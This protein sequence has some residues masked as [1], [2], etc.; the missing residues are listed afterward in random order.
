MVVAPRPLRDHLLYCPPRNGSM[1]RL[2]ILLQTT[3]L[4]ASAG[5]G[6][7]FADLI[8]EHGRAPTWLLFIALV[9]GGSAATACAIQLYELRRQIDG[10]SSVEGM[11]RLSRDDISDWA[12]AQIERA[13]VV[14]V[15]GTARQHVLNQ[16]DAAARYLTA[17]EARVRSA[18]VSYRRIAPRQ[19]TNRFRSHLD[20]LVESGARNGG[21]IAVLYVLD[22]TLCLSYQVFDERAAVIVVDT[23]RVPGLRDNTVAMTT[24]DHDIIQGLI[25]HF[26]HAWKHFAAASESEV[27]STESE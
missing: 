22:T 16:S 17:T 7:L 18:R 12:S 11:E 3:L 10:A 19:L 5:F 2:R 26:D 9:S 1:S 24:R 6:A 4:L 14:R 23:E 27:V 13:D 25:H 15:I 8:S 20:Q 21:D